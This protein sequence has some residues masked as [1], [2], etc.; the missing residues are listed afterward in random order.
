MS[1]PRPS[2]ATTYLGVAFEQ[3]CAWLDDAARM[4]RLLGERADLIAEYD[5]ACQLQ[6]EAY[7]AMYRL[8]LPS[9]TLGYGAREVPMD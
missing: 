2:I 3:A 9:Y 8:P 4:I 5:A 7:C 6:T 1:Q